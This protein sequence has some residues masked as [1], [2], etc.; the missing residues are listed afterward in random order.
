MDEPRSS[1]YCSEVSRSLKKLH[2]LV[3]LAQ[4]KTEKRRLVIATLEALVGSNSVPTPRAQIV[5]GTNMRPKIP[6]PPGAGKPQ[7]RSEDNPPR[8]VQP[9][10]HRQPGGPGV[11]PEAQQR[12]NTKT[13]DKTL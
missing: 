3:W 11:F 8:T 1:S 9:L 10:Q 4:R 2:S 7:L 12:R 6:V 5:N 13:Q